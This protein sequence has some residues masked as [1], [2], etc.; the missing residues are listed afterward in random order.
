MGKNLTWDDRIADLAHCQGRSPE[1]YAA[2]FDFALAIMRVPSAGAAA[3]APTAAIAPVAVTAANSPAAAP[4]AGA[5]V[6][7]DGPSGPSALALALALALARD[8][9]TMS[10]R[11]IRAARSAA[12]MYSRSRVF[13]T[14]SEL[15]APPP[16]LPRAR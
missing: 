11:R 10:L 8:Q 7:V 6:A 12:A 4:A 5:G 13:W 1:D 3:A 9:S 16:G 2:G 14:R 15:S